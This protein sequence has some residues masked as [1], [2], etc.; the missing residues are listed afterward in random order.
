MYLL[1]QLPPTEGDE[2]MFASEPRVACVVQPHA[3]LELRALDGGISPGITQPTPLA[4]MVVGEGDLLPVLF[5]L[6]LLISVTQD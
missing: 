4:K 1:L 6:D 5:H 3:L 2:Q